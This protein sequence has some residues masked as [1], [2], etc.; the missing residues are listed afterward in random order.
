MWFLYIMIGL[1]L[2]AG[3][4]YFI[5]KPKMKTFAKLDTETA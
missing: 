1:L 4:V 3:A 5:Q 2:G